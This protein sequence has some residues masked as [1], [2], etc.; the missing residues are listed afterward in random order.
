MVCRRAQRRCRVA[1]CR[2]TF[3]SRIESPSLPKE[4]DDR[5]HRHNQTMMSVVSPRMEEPDLLHAPDAVRGDVRVP[6]GWHLPRIEWI[7]KAERRDMPILVKPQE[8]MQRIRSVLQ[9]RNRGNLF[10]TIRSRTQTRDQ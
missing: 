6:I 7:S 5:Q 3:A 4:D 9:S 1:A 10:Q 2:R 8:A